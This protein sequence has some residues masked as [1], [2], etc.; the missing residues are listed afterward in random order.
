M[1]DK[2]FS[3]VV[4]GILL[5][6]TLLSS[7]QLIAANNTAVPDTIVTKDWPG[8]TPVGGPSRSRERAKIEN[9]TK[10]KA[11]AA[12]TVDL[13]V[14]ADQVGLTQWVPLS[15]IGGVMARAVVQAYA[16]S[17]ETLNPLL[18]DACEFD[19][20][21]DG[22]AQI[23][24]R[25]HSD[26]GSAIRLLWYTYR[27]QW[28]LGPVIGSA[29]KFE[30]IPAGVRPGFLSD[31]EK[32]PPIAVKVGNAQWTL[33]PK[34]PWMPV[35]S[36]YIGGD[37]RA[38]SDIETSLVRIAEPPA[39]AGNTGSQVAWTQFFTNPGDKL[40]AQNVPLHD[41][42]APTIDDTTGEFTKPDQAAFVLIKNPV[43]CASNGALCPFVILDNALH[44]RGIMTTGTTN[45][46][47]LVET[48]GDQKKPED[49][50]LTRIYGFDADGA[51]FFVS[52]LR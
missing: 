52:D 5:S 28:K 35:N 8:L 48:I 41:D 39:V 50:I 29:L 22:N 20:V 36:V 37:T 26:A 49:K 47:I 32:A 51:P 2:S 25:V 9:E 27:H 7:G 31:Q 18:V 44:G 17:G 33:R 42:K 14:P 40:V 16:N 34:G 43:F 15:G 46:G 13:S 11:D 4:A 12:P 1:R 10:I 45:T 24:I 30:R 19:V 3:K 6:C 21:G 23:A 38:P